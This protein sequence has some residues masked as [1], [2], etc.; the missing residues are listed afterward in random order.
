MKREELTKI[1]IEL[2]SFLFGAESVWAKDLGQDLFELRNAPF[3]ATHLNYGDVVK[4]IS[5]K[6]QW[7]PHFKKLVRRGPHR[8]WRFVFRNDTPAKDRKSLLKKITKL[9]CALEGMNGAL[10]CV[11]IPPK[12]NVSKVKQLLSVHP[13]KVWY[14]K[15]W[16][17]SL[18]KEMNQE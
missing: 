3:F 2:Q 16:P 17:K 9:N 15:H 11:S 7:N 5:P 6:R 12:S 1:I 14:F 4:A 8:T 18:I 10:I 13:A